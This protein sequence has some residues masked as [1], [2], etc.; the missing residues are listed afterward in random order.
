MSLDQA[1]DDILASE[2]GQDASIATD[3]EGPYDCRVV[4]QSEESEARAEGDSELSAFRGVVS[5]AEVVIA[6]KKSV[7]QAVPVI[8][9]NFYLDATRYRVAGTEITGPLL[10]LTLRREDS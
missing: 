1:A 10:E 6:F 4:L 9:Q 2:L 7:L 8:D 5:E 3:E